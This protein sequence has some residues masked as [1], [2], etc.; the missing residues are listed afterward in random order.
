MAKRTTT[1]IQSLKRSIQGELLVPGDSGYD[2]AR[3]MW[4]GMFDRKPGIIARC[5]NTSDVV[6]AV[7]YARDHGLLLAVKGGGHNSAGNGVCDDGLTID[8]SLMRNATVDPEKGTATIEGGCLLGDADKAT[9]KHGLAV[10]AGIVSHTGVGGLTLGGGFGWISRKHGFTIDN[11]LSAEMVTADGRVVRASVSENPDLFWAIRG[12][13]GNFGV[14][15]R[16]E[17]RCAEIGTHVYSGFIVKKFEDARQY[18][19]F[20]REYVRTM[21]DEM[22]IWMVIRHAPPL[23]FLPEDV[24]GKLVVIIPFVWLGDQARGEELLKPVREVTESHGEAIGMNPWSGWQSGFDP[25]VEH[26]ARNYWK[27]HHLKDLSDG[28]VDSI[29]QFAETMPTQEVEILVPHMEGAPSR[30]PENATAFAHRRTPFL[31]NIHT[32]WREAADDARCLAWV[33]EFHTATEPFA[34][35]VYVNFLSEEGDSRIRDA[36]TPEVWDRLV[37]AKRTWDPNNLFRM[38]QNINPNG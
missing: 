30:V 7:N 32:R 19:E 29:L 9:E 10:S 2:E 28:C 14:V 22:T 36:Y 34:Q 16:F 17:F 26:G 23:P 18:I 1:D 11:L 31:L 6:S 4:N 35:G 33:R 8:L 12:G 24:H 38:N 13:G 25:L 3:S 27:S 20:H 21:P 5:K 37:Q 15:T